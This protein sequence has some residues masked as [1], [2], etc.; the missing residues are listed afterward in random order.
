MDL[1][2][3]EELSAR[4]QIA[5]DQIVREE[6]ELLFLRDIFASTFGPSLVFKGG[7]ALRLAYGAPRFSDNL[8]F[9]ALSPIKKKNF[10]DFI[11][12]LGHRYPTVSVAEARKKYY[13]LFGL[14]KI[15]E[16]FLKLPFSIK[17]EI[18][19]RVVDWQPDLDF[20]PQRLASPVSNIVVAGNTATLERMWQ[21]KKRAVR[22]RKKSRDIYDLWYLAGRLNKRF[23]PP[24]HGL[25]LEK[26]KAE[27]NRVLP[28]NERYAVD[29]LVKP[30]ER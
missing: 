24:K 8:D 6:Y 27:L 21:D 18:S 25:S 14:L 17:I 29:Y 30:V 9:S 1:L 26:L 5:K 15:K 4:L 20:V 2:T 10:L 7:T 13:T 23:I 12:I 28:K 19:T 16:E 11:Q 22:T 3:A